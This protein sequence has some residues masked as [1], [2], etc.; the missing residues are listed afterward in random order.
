[1]TPETKFSIDFDWWEK[2]N[3]DLKTYLY[4]RLAIGADVK[5]E[6]DFDIVDL[7]DSET[8]EVRQVEGFQYA[9]QT[10]FNQLPDDFAKRS[11]LVD[12]V[13]CVLLGN[14]NQPMSAAA[15]A[16]RIH[17]PTNVVM[18]TLGGAKIYQGIRPLF[19]DV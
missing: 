13:F 8:G 14:A 7:V 2:S 4:S 10:Y 17:R 3:L 1:M 19:D 16:Q 15:I 18:K 5:L 11:S 12:A 6:S 9:L